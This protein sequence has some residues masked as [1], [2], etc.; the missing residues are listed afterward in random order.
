LALASDDEI[1]RPSGHVRRDVLAPAVDAITEC[2]RRAS[3][4][5]EEQSL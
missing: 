5:I 1:G 3:E 2:R 4:V